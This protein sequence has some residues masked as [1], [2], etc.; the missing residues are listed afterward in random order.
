MVIYENNLFE[1]IL[2]RI[3]LNKN[4]LENFK[5]SCIR[6]DSKLYENDVIKLYIK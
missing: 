5:N 3:N 4:Q 1:E 2:Y 6:N